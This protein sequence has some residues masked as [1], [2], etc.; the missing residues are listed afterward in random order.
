M[1]VNFLDTLSYYLLPWCDANFTISNPSFS[2]TSKLFVV[3]LLSYLLTPH[4]YLPPPPL[5]PT[6]A[7]LLKEVGVTPCA[8]A[9]A[10]SGLV[11]AATLF[12]PIEFH[13]IRCWRNCSG[14]HHSKLL[15]A[16]LREIISSC[17]V[18]C[19]VTSPEAVGHWQQGRWVWQRG[20]K[21][22]ANGGPGMW[23]VVKNN[24]PSPI[25]R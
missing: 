21:W 11:S 20:T 3:K 18:K 2:L 16:V 12:I 22:L 1:C 10:R 24:L 25:W 8:C 15:S 17:Q 4:P 19:V 5:P 14:V 9:C 23:T 13:I 6:G 7:F